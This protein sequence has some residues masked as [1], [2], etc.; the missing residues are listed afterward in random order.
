MSLKSKV[1]EAFVAVV[2]AIA[3]LPPTVTV[4]R[5]AEVEKHRS[6]CVVCW[7][8]GGPEEPMASGN[9]MMAVTIIIKSDA[10]KYR[11]GDGSDL[12][13]LDNLAALAELV[14]PALKTDD[15]GARLTAAFNG[16]FY[17][18]DPVIDTGFDPD[19]ADVSFV[20]SLSFNVYCCDTNVDPIPT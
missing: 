8:K 17:A 2:K 19:F 12:Q 13:P 15:L 18:Y 5:G 14:F 1:E 3:G 6:P 11:K 16:E 10:V 20:E 4:F 9:R 7:C